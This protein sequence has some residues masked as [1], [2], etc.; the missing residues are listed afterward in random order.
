MRREWSSA[1]MQGRGVGRDGRPRENPP[2]GGIARHDSHMREPTPQS[3]A[4]WSLSCVF[5]GCCPAPGSYGIRKVFPRKSSIGSETCRAGLINCGPIAKAETHGKYKDENA[6]LIKCTIATKLEA[7]NWRASSVGAHRVS[8][9][10]VTHARRVT[11]NEIVKQ[12]DHEVRECKRCEK[13]EHCQRTNSHRY[14]YHGEIPALR[15]DGIF[16]T[17]DSIALIARAPSVLQMSWQR[18]RLY[19]PIYTRDIIVCVA[20][21][22]DTQ[23]RYQQSG[24][25]DPH[26]SRTQ[27]DSLTR[28]ACQPLVVLRQWPPSS[29]PTS[30]RFVSHLPLPATSIT[31]NTPGLINVVA[32]PTNSFLPTC[33]YAELREG[34][35][36]NSGGGGFN[37]SQLSSTR[38]YASRLPRTVTLHVIA[39]CDPPIL[40]KG[41]TVAKQLARSPPTKANRVQSPAGSPDFR[42]RE[43]CR[44]MPLIGGFFFSGISRFHHPFIPAPLE[45]SLQSPS[46]ALK[47]SL[48]RAATHSLAP[49]LR[50]TLWSVVSR[51]NPPC[52][53]RAE[54]RRTRTMAACA[55]TTTGSASR[56]RVVVP[57]SRHSSC[58][59]GHRHGWS[60]HA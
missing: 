18:A 26:A 57:P 7:L 23:C 40:C 13:R 5:I 52:P 25:G 6:T 50:R 60:C 27:A 51:Y 33:L 3:S 9:I 46:S 44:T 14:K 31:R 22:T 19:R 38:Q 56:R 30:C 54:P 42:K 55:T 4:Y 36:L 20:C 29:Q 21:R 43:S 24:P 12:R 41:T 2:T 15:G 47:T 37:S 1:G 53:R 10:D 17:F 8:S 28:T 16:L 59:H 58:R 39:R 11:L 45:Y 34:T 32:I 35:L 48:L 49:V